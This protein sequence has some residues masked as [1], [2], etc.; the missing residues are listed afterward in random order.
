MRIYSH[1]NYTLKGYTRL[2][3]EPVI[4][5][6]EMV[7]AVADSVG[8]AMLNMHPLE[9]CPIDERGNHRCQRELVVAGAPYTHQEIEAPPV[10]A[11]MVPVR[12]GGWPKGR[13]RK[14]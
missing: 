12:R 2:T 10:H 5:E 6:A 1:I 9:F 4:F 7:V 8:E 13:S 3:H 14:G 11:Q